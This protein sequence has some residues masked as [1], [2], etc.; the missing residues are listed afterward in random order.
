MSVQS[1][2]SRINHV[3]CLRPASLWHNCGVIHNENPFPQGADDP[4]RRLRGRIGAGVTVITAGDEDHRAGLTVSSLVVIEGEPGRVVAVVGPNSDLYDI[5]SATGKFVLHLCEARHAGL[6]DVFAGI[7]PS[8]GGM[9][10]GLNV[11]DTEWG[12]SIQTIETRAFCSEGTIEPL[13]WSGLLTGIIDKVEFGA[14]PSPLI[15]YRGG[16]RGLS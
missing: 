16:Y 5:A 1:K 8:P 4:T 7:R 2:L 3:S 11:T 9:F 12:P 15:H 13:G 14:D 6:A 10:S